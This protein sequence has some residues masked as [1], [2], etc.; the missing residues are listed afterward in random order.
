MAIKRH[1][2]G[3]IKGLSNDTK[4]VNSE[5]SAEFTESNT[6]KIFDYTSSTSTWTERIGEIRGKT[7]PS[8]TTTSLDFNS[9]QLQTISISANTTFTTTGLASG[10]SKTIKITTDGT[11]RTL[12]FPAWKFVGSKPANQAAS[13][14]GIL[15]LTSFGTTDAECVA[16]YAVEA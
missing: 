8:A 14:I 9:D 11:L 2:A 13:K 10:K 4:P 16:A 6:G 12:T 7:T 15:T 3:K 5:D 1:G